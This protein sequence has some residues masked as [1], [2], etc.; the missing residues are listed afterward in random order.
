MSETDWIVSLFLSCFDSD[1][2]K[3]AWE[4]SDNYRKGYLRQC[5]NVALFGKTANQWR[6][7]NPDK[8]GNIR[9]D[10]N[11]NQL[12]VLANLESYNAILIGQGKTMSERLVLLRELAIRQ[13]KTLVAVSMDG[14]EQLPGG[15]LK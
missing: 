3:G 8:K 12:L 14:L 9:D 4:G 2:W 15:N 10:A 6:D 7:T 13:M 5:L 1:G 11:L